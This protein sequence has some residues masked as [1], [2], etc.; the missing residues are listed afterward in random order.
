MRRTLRS[1]Y[2]RIVIGVGSIGS[3]Q[4]LLIPVVWNTDEGL[5]ATMGRVSQGGHAFY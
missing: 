3:W 5:Q 1:D 2:S 4:I